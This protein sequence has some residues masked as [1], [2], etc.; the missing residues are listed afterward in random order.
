MQVQDVSPMMPEI[1]FADDPVEDLEDRLKILSGN[2]KE[3][4]APVRFG[5]RLAWIV[6][7]YKDAVYGLGN[8][9][10]VPAKVE[11]ITNWDTQGAQPLKMQ[12]D[13]HR[14][15]RA[16]L[17]APFKPAEVRRMADQLL[18]PTADRL[19]DDFGD[20]RTVDLIADFTHRYSFLIISGILGVPVKDEAILRKL[21]Y[22]MLQ[23]GQGNADQR[24]PAAIAAVKRM[25]EYLRPIVEDRRRDPRDDVISYLVQA[26][27]DGQP[28][29]EE[30][31]FDYIRFLYPAGAET[32]HVAM[33]HLF[34]RVLSD[35]ALKQRLIAHPED[36]PAVVDEVMRY[37]PP[38]MLQPRILERDT[39]IAGRD[40]PAGSKLLIS[41][42]NGNRDPEIFA[43]PDS[44]SLD[45]RRKPILS[46]GIGPHF[47]IG[48]HLAKAEM[49]VSL[50]RLLERLP[51]LRLAKPAPPLIGTQVRWLT[52]LVAEFDDI[53]PA[54]KADQKGN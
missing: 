3:R 12:G 39:N 30:T 54:K 5:G 17:E 48:T 46:F 43:E 24:R 20:R 42:W 21:V 18:V 8:D 50:G 1:D 49:A 19:I 36:R 14:R 28:L 52:E 37:T 47:C 45:H 10:D 2:G 23:G 27:V 32:T 7:G 33:G 11:Y 15:S 13:E 22:D 16:L 9:Q 26:K 53:L 4:I 51:G 40:L 25:N 34:Q 41:I 31:L 6:F 44:F 35:P 29:D 38:A